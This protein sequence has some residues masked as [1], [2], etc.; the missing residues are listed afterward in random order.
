M[1]GTKRKSRFSIIS[2]NYPLDSFDVT[3]KLILFENRDSAL[4]TVLI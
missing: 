1:V 3:L 4:F 2:P